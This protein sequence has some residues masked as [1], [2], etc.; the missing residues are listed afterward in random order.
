MSG[1]N[2]EALYDLGYSLSAGVLGTPYA[3]YR[4]SSANNPTDAANLVG[5]IDAWLTTDPALKGTKPPQYGKPDWFAAI[6]RAGLQAGDYLIGQNG[7]FIVNSLLYPQPVALWWCNRIIG[8]T[9]PTIGNVAGVSP[10]SGDTTASQEPVMAGWPCFQTMVGSGST[11][12]PTGMKLPSDAQFPLVVFRLSLA[13]PLAQFNDVITDDL[14]RRY[15]AHMV[16]QLPLGYTITA[17]QVT[18]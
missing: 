10:Y 14:G 8:V 9:R 2:L 6:E 17:Q 3:Q 7:T 15:Y 13:A 11:G 1:A 12:K 16:D 4:A 5:T 18:I